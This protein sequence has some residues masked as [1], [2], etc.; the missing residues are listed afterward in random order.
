[1]S[2]GAAEIETPPRGRPI[3]RLAL[4]LAVFCLTLAGVAGLNAW[5]DP[6]G[7]F[8]RDGLARQATARLLAGEAIRASNVDDRAL[9]RAYAAAMPVPPETLVL[10]SSRMM[11]VSAAMTGDGLYN[12]AVGSAT[13]RDLVALAVLFSEGDGMPARVVIGLDTW[14]LDPG[15]R[16]DRWRTLADAYARGRAWLSLPPVEAAPADWAGKAGALVSLAYGLETLSALRADWREA[17]GLRAVE[18]ETVDPARDDGPIERPDGSLRYARDYLARDPAR[19]RAD[20]LAQAR[21]LETDALRGA[22]LAPEAV[23]EIEALLD[24]L[25]RAGAEVV[26]IL[27]PFHPAVAAHLTAAG[28]GAYLPRLEERFRAMA[29]RRGLA[30]LGGYD[31][32][33]AGCAGDAFV[34][35]I[36]PRPDC[37][38]RILAGLRR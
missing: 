38:A 31:P 36:H 19:I 4:L 32:A 23:A 8:A 15:L 35:G 5:V 6:A 9:Q 26:L 33:R 3:R 34:D 11:A 2:P 17:L 13:R 7:L 1:M 10:G 30:I 27:P 29:A 14:L 20:A 16:N 37:M 21:K 28:Q 24:A 12:A 18:I 25:A 22:E